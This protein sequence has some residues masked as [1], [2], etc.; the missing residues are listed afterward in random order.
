MVGNIINPLTANEAEF[1]ITIYPTDC[2]TSMPNAFLST[3]DKSRQKHTSTTIKG[4]KNP[5]LKN[6]SE[7]DEMNSPPFICTIIFNLSAA[8]DIGLEPADS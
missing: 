7:D 1:R 4:M 2:T 8:T 5:G 3:V 6:M